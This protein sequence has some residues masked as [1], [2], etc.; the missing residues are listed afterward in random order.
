M[1]NITKITIPSLVLTMSTADPKGSALSV[2]DQYQKAA[3]DQ[4]KE[5]IKKAIGNKPCYYSNQ[6]R[7]EVASEV[8]KPF[9]Y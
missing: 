9:M 5:L 1:R 7:D 4:F 8:K 3:A 2:A 6:L